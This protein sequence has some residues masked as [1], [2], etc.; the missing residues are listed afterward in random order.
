MGLAQK[1][2]AAEA[3]QAAQHGGVYG[4][5]PQQCHAFRP[6]QTPESYNGG[7]PPLGYQQPATFPR[8]QQYVLYSGAPPEQGQ[9]GI[10]ISRSPSSRRDCFMDSHQFQEDLLKI[11]D[12]RRETV[13]LHE[14]VLV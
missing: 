11:L 3:A 9:D 14:L 6:S 13:R 2:A 8:S 7:P 1:M 5:P 10:G 4:P 12:L